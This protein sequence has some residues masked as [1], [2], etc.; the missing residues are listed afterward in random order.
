[1]IAPRCLKPSVSVMNPS[2]PGTPGSRFGLV[3]TTS[4]H[5]LLGSGGRAASLPFSIFCLHV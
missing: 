4:I 1:M 2:C 5:L 3:L